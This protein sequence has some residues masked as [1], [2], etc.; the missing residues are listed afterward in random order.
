MLAEKKFCLFHLKPIVTKLTLSKTDMSFA[1]PE[2]MY[3]CMS[4]LTTLEKIL[5]QKEVER[6]LVRCSTRHRFVISSDNPSLNL[7]VCII[8]FEGQHETEISLNIYDRKWKNLNCRFVCYLQS[9]K[10]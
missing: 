9:I 1:K 6:T 2:V 10:L 5:S 8:S 7:S 4:I 3:K